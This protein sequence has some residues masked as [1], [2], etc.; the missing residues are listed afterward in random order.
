MKV[1]GI[2]IYPGIVCGKAFVFSNASDPNISIAADTLEDLKEKEEAFKIAVAKAHEQISAAMN[3]TED[4]GSDVYTILDAHL[5][6]L[7][8]DAINEDILFSLR[9]GNCVS[10]AI[11]ET[12]DAYNEILRNSESDFTKE[13]TVDMD[14]IRRSLIRCLSGEK[15]NSLRDLTSPSI[16]VAKDLFPSDTA[17]LNKDMVLAILTEEGGQTS[18]T[19]ILARSLGIPTIL[20][21][22][23]IT[24]LIKCE[25]FLGVNAQSGEI[26][27]NPSEIELSILEKLKYSLLIEHK[28]NLSYK[29]AVA[30][31]LDG[32]IIHIKLNVSEA[33]S[34]MDDDVAASDGVGLMRSEFLYM[35]SKYLPDE[36]EQY[37][38]YCN[39]LKKFN[40]KPVILRTLDI[41]G[42]KTLPALDLPKEENPSLGCRAVRLCFNKP[43][44][45]RT[46]LRAALRAS[47]HGP[48]QLMFPMIGSLDDWR[49]AKG[50]VESIKEELEREDMVFNHN[51]PL[52][53]M[54]EIPSAVFMSDHLAREVDFASVGTNDLCQYLN[55]ADRLNPN[56]SQYYQTFS[57]AML[58]ILRYIAQQYEAVNTPL[59]ICGE[60]GG[61]PRATAILV[62]LGF[63]SLSMNAPSLGGVKQTICHIS[64]ADAQRLAQEACDAG[65]QE[66]V[67]HQ[68]EVF[69]QSIQLCKGGVS[70]A[71]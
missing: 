22:G 45:F 65:T 59:G 20:G 52:G 21:A 6:L 68:L 46:Q 66:Q 49:K 11:N 13:R 31:T 53:A 1:V 44:I 63:R 18:H 3:L 28:K 38:A 17:T 34:I 71:Y 36:E 25:D 26:F 2:S 10:T 24:S 39:V 5:T 7:H 54:I 8:D 55:A 57:P 70:N 16:I 41:G 58:R 32:T 69:H 60:M 37:K 23:K 64:L 62:G 12:F 51:I 67:L 48:L 33:N 9:S 43:E 19:A 30:K 15:E 14:D 4:K 50:F 42:D 47:A 40:N 35:Q 29:N 27:I 56:V 61:D